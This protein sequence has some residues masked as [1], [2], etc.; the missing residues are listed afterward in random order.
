ML[1]DTSGW[2]HQQEL[3]QQWERNNVI[4]DELSKVQ[5]KIQD[6]LIKIKQLTREAWHGQKRDNDGSETPF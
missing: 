1:D 4:L 2:H 6:E 5:L 3:E